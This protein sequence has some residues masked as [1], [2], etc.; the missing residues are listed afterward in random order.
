MM[1]FFIELIL[2]LLMNKLVNFGM[3][4]FIPNYYLAEILSSVLFAF[5]FAL[6]EQWADRRHFYKYQRF[7]YTFF[8][9]GICFCLLD[10][11]YFVI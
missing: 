4:L 9:T 7:W 3:H 2:I 1:R 5:I 6:I 8:I 11:I 10:L